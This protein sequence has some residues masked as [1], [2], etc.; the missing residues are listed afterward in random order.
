MAVSFTVCKQ[1]S[2]AG[3]FTP[4]TLSDTVLEQFVTALGT[5]FLPLRPFTLVAPCSTSESGTCRFSPLLR[6][7]LSFFILG[8][9]PSS[10]LFVT[11][12]CSLLAVLPPVIS[13]LLWP[14]S[15]SF[16]PLATH[17]SSLPMLTTVAAAS[18]ILTA[19]H[20]LRPRY[21]LQNQKQEKAIWEKN[22][23]LLISTN[24]NR[25]Q[26]RRVFSN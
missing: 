3:T 22:F 15:P 1:A 12:L 8:S 10:A 24:G 25:S 6:H 9:L 17:P 23:M 13:A 5:E 18:P 4:T 14:W 26:H 21:Y 11:V 7:L 19:C 2:G 16:P 20:K